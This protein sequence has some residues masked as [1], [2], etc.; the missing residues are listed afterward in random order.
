MD[1]RFL[2]IGTVVKLINSDDKVIIIGY[3]MKNK[4]GYTYDYCGC[5]YPIGITDKHNNFYF[6]IPDIIEVIKLGLVDK[7][8]KIF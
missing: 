3:L 2:P 7:E 1:N 6:N 8:T 5:K 4:R